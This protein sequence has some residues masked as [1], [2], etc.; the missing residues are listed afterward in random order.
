MGH[1]SRSNSISQSYSEGDDGLDQNQL[2]E[3]TDSIRNKNAIKTVDTFC[4][5]TLPLMPNNSAKLPVYYG[6]KYGGM[7]LYHANE[8][9]L[10][11]AT[12]KVSSSIM[13]TQLHKVGSN[14]V[15]DKVSE[16]V[17]NYAESHDYTVNKCTERFV[18]EALNSTI[19]S[20]MSKG[21]DAL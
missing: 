13:T 14:I 19:S 3:F 5:T 17:F 6:I 18:E 12:S 8:N 16:E 4:S 2:K 21:S 10:E 11:T 1:S 7:F 9:D 15:A 20:I